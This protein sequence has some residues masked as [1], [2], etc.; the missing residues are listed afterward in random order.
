MV[1]LLTTARKNAPGRNDSPHPRAKNSWF[2]KES[3]EKRVFRLRDFK[4]KNISTSFFTV[5]LYQAP[6]WLRRYFLPGFEWNHLKTIIFDLEKFKKN[7]ISY[8]IST[9]IAYQVRGD[10]VKKKRGVQYKRKH[11]KLLPQ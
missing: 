1:Y 6:G 3:F 5:Y 7:L 10:K 8:G 11:R 2:S 4:F 9:V